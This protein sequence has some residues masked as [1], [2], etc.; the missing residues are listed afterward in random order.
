MRVEFLEPARSEFNEAVDYYEGRQPGLGL[1]FEEEVKSTIQRIA[2]FPAAWSR[3]SER[4]RRCRT[5]KFPYGIIYQ[6]KGD[7]LLV[8]AVMHLHRDPTTWRE[9]LSGR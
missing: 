5:N 7:V 3:L 8:V 6:V 2:A 4:T 9:R 1:K